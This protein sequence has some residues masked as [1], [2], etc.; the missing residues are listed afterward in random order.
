LQLACIVVQLALGASMTPEQTTTYQ[1]PDGHGGVQ[2]ASAADF[3]IQQKPEK[4]I[5]FAIYNYSSN[6][7]RTNYEMQAT[8]HLIKVKGLLQDNK[9][10]FPSEVIQEDKYQRTY[11]QLLEDTIIEFQRQD[12][13]ALDGPLSITYSDPLIAVIQ[14]NNERPI[15]QRCVTYKLASPPQAG[16]VL[17]EKYYLKS[18]LHLFDLCEIREMIIF[19]DETDELWMNVELTDGH[20]HR[21]FFRKFKPSLLSSADSLF[22][23]T[24]DGFFGFNELQNLLSVAKNPLEYYDIV[25][26]NTDSIGNIVISQVDNWEKLHQEPITED[27]QSPN[28]TGVSQNPAQLMYAI[29]SNMSPKPN[30][31][32]TYTQTISFLTMK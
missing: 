3:K 30:Y 11:K 24:N 13:M 29:M 17:E 5:I 22:N 10:Y 2:P 6:E 16:R 25:A 7:A 21:V 19:V 15:I 26:K 32:T 12:L 9:H 4:K 1:S 18:I 14:T 27:Y 8:D 23:N 20:A 28:T 31:Y